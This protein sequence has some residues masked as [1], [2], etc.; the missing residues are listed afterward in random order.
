M[1]PR[2]YQVSYACMDSPSLLSEPV[3]CINLHLTCCLFVG[4]TS[5]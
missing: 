2:H 3:S 5:S 4:L 1:S